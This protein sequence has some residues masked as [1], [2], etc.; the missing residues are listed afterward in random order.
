MVTKE[1]IEYIK[2]CREQNIS[3]EQIK[4]TLKEQSWT[5][6]DI[7]TGLSQISQPTE[8]IQ[9]AQSTETQ[10]PK[11]KF[12]IPVII[13][14]GTLVVGGG[15]FAYFHFFGSGW[16]VF[17]NT[18]YGFEVEY[19]NDWYAFEDM[20]NRI[21][22]TYPPEEHKEYFGTEDYKKLGDNLGIIIISRE[23]KSQ[24]EKLNS[25]KERY[26]KIINGIDK[27]AKIDE[28]KTEEITIGKEGGYKIY[29][30]YR[31]SKIMY[32]NGY[33]VIYLLSDKNRTGVIQFEGDFSGNNE[34][35]YTDYAEKFGEILS[36]FEFLD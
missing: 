19:P 33:H 15:I 28:I 29:F 32:E 7:N 3:N 6:E 2:T 13:I 16:Q 14:I 26:A 22:A 5:D 25:I 18:E 17:R 34:Q 21:I 36:T 31:E 24:E 4:L 20:G 8:V 10:K 12:L 11:K 35:I 1:L 27:S 30:N 23:T 9:S